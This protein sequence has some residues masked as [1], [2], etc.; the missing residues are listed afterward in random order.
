MAGLGD[1]TS[2]AAVEKAIAEF[3]Q[4]GRPH[5]SRNMSFAKRALTFFFKMAN[6]TIPKP[7]SAPRSASN[8]HK[9]ARWQDAILWADWPQ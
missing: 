4:L 7:S 6:A 1:L 5:F 3:D 2:A 9:E 8:I